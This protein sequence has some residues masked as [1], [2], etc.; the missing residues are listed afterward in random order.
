MYG[1]PPNLDLSFFVGRE[2]YSVHFAMHSL[3]LHFDGDVSVTVTSSVGYMGSDGNIQ[4]SEDFREAAP[5]VLALLNQTI[6]YAEGTE[7]GTLT[8]KF[9]GGGMLIIYD[10]SKHY[11]SYTI[12]NGTQTI[13]V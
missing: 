7:A 12:T 13:V 2:L 10:D 6:L 5:A 3:I 11:E 8:L 4:Q 1:L 9:D